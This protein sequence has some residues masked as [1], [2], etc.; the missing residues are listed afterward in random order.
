MKRSVI[1]ACMVA[2]SSCGGNE[3]ANKQDVNPAKRKVVAGEV[4]DR[5]RPQHSY[6]ILETRNE[7]GVRHHMV[8]DRM[9]TGAKGRAMIMDV[10]GRGDG[11]VTIV[12]LDCEGPKGMTVAGMH[13]MK[14]FEEKDRAMFSRRLMKRKDDYQ[15]IICRKSGKNIINGDRSNLQKILLNV[16]LSPLPD[17]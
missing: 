1:I 7:D 3:V 17:R 8:L 10:D 5:S 13:E 14:A 12:R 9:M 4:L 6:Q 11:T 16:P 2:L 15:K